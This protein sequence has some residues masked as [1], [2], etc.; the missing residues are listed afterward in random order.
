MTAASHEGWMLA[1]A[2]SVNMSVV[3]MSKVRSRV[4]KATR[5]GWKR[6]RCSMKCSVVLRTA[7]KVRGRHMCDG[8][9][10]VLCGSGKAKRELLI[11]MWLIWLL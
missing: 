8:E 6:G 9:H 11:T 10:Q 1:A 5:W 3:V 4:C 2:S 7:V